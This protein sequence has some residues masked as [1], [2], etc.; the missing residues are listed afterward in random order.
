MG[1][2]GVDTAILAGAFGLLGVGVMVFVSRRRG[3]MVHCTAYCPMGLVANV[4]GRLS[5][6][7]I[8]INSDCTPV[9][10]VLFPLPLQRLER[11]SGRE[12]DARHLLHVVRGLCPPPVP[13]GI[14]VTAFPGLSPERARTVFLVLA[15]SLHALFLGVARI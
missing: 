2:S 10:G 11:P 6:W 5:P 1:V 3:M 13:M 8:R 7:R 12:G 4:L 15:V 14:S 9:R